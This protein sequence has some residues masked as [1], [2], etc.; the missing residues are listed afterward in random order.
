MS[1]LVVHG[2]RE[3]TVTLTWKPARDDVG[4]ARYQ[5]YGSQEPSFVPGVETLLGES[6]TNSF[7][8][9][10]NLGVSWYFSVRGV[11]H[12]GNV[13]KISEQASGTTGSVLKIEAESLLP[14]VEASAPAV[15]QEDCCGV[16]R[17][18]G[19][20]I[21]FQ[22]R[23][24]GDFY[25]LAFEA[26]KAGTY[27]LSVFFLRAGDFGIHTV[28]FDGAVVGQPFDGY[29]PE[30]MLS[31]RVGFGRAEFRA[32]RHTVAFTVTG[33]NPAST[34]FFVGVDLLEL[35]LVDQAFRGA[36]VHA[37]PGGGSRDDGR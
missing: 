30:V 29:S 15:Y 17:S 10:A 24:P 2:N 8:H 25:T 26:P 32:G 21:L 7:T 23:K 1:G 14:A 3:N 35:E 11:D 36:D 20:Q 37:K 19:A 16:Q 18:G 34:G 13:G 27:D 28:M 5:V 22:A 9:P 12:A 31:G 4:V 6:T 33:K